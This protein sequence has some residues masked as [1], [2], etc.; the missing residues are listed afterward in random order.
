MAGVRGDAA[1][2]QRARAADLLLARV[3]RD[4]PGV[5]RHR[6][7]AADRDA[8]R[9]PGLADHHAPRSR[10]GSS[11]SRSSTRSATALAKPLAAAIF[12]MVNGC[13]L[14]GAERYRRRAEV[15]E[16][17]AREGLNAEGGRRLDTLEFKEA[18][19]IGT[20]Q[21]SALIAGISRDGVVHDRRARPRPG[22]LRRRPV[23]ASC[24]RPRRSWPPGCCKFG[25]LTGPLGDGGVRSAAVIAAIFAAI[26]AVDHRALPDPVLQARQPDP[27]RDLLPRCSARS[28]SCSRRLGAPSRNLPATSLADPGLS[29]SGPCRWSG[30][31]PGRGRRSPAAWSRP[32]TAA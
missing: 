24:L 20:A 11:A 30:L 27:V 29:R 4:H 15:R 23:R 1:R 10:S 13:I 18:A 5:L 17:A 3:D 31:A 25:D 12:L 6:R 21:S 28:W 22:Q 19:V 32:G 8:D 26:T 16:L 14:L 9:A 7:E 2:R